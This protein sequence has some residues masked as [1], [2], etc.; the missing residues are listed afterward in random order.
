V[1]ADSPRG[2]ALYAESCASCH[3]VQGEGAEGPALQNRVLLDSASDTY[4]VETTARGR[5]GTSMP[6][7]RI[8]SPVHRSLTADEIEAVVSFLRTWESDS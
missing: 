7:F 6:S 2:A 4:L 1:Q 8:G 5:R 3:G